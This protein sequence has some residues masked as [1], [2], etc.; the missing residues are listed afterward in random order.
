MTQN[1]NSYPMINGLNHS[2]SV[3]RITI[4]NSGDVK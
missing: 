1:K 2:S 4:H 3:R